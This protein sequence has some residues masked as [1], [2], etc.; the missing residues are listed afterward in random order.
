VKYN[1]FMNVRRWWKAGAFFIVEH[2]LF[3]DLPQNTG[4][5][6]EYQD[7]AR[8]EMTI[9][10]AGEFQKEYEGKR[11]GLLLEGE[12]VAEFCTDGHA[13]K[14]ASAVSVVRH[15]KGKI[16]LSCLDLYPYLADDSK[17]ANTVKKILCNYIEYTTNAVNTVR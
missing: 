13:F 9:D 17:A 3:K 2:P 1:G 8:Y 7:I 16:V 11:Y 6:W 4:M 15:G 10:S 14:V 12:E 5:N